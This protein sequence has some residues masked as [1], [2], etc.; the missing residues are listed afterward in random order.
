MT[1][2]GHTTVRGAGD[3]SGHTWAVLQ[4]GPQKAVSHQDGSQNT[5]GAGHTPHRKTPEQGP[6]SR[7]H[8]AAR[9]TAS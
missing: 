2:R 8:Q 9:H 1:A 3:A 5:P 6:Q 4:R 7:K